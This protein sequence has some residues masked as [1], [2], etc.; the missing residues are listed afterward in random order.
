MFEQLAKWL[1]ESRLHQA[2][3]AADWFVPAVQTIHILGIAVVVTCLMMLNVRMLRSLEVTPPLAG[4]AR[5]FMPWTWRALGAL[6]LTGVLLVISEPSRELTST[7]FRL[8]MMLVLL[9]TALAITVQSTLARDAGYWH[10]SSLRR[11]ISRIISVTSLLLCAA[12][13]AAGR[14]IAY[15]AHQ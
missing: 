1:E 2:F 11:V 3:G 12:I 9:L 14:L 5:R 15:T 10:S 13:V 8:K 7:A 6:L 4:M